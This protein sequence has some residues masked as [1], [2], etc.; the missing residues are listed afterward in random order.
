MESFFTAMSGIGILFLLGYL[1]LTIFLIVYFF[2]MAN[3]MR[4]LK[5]SLATIKKIM[6]KKEWDDAAKEEASKEATK[7]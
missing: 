5:D 2:R 6:V 4:E 1:V 7:D 3:D